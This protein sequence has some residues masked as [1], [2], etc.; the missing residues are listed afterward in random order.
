MAKENKILRMFRLLTEKYNAQVGKARNK[1]SVEPP[2]TVA[3]TVYGQRFVF[4][5]ESDDFR[6]FMV[7]TAREEL[8]EA[9]SSAN[10]KDLRLQLE[11]I[12]S[13]METPERDK[14]IGCCG[15]PVDEPVDDE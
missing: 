6:I 12:A 15:C 14:K 1:G 13:P 8:G 3:L 9:F 10:L 5:T 4:S 2:L 7:R 11:T